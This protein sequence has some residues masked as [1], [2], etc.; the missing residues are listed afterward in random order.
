VVS[1][2]KK[3]TVVNIVKTE[4]SIFE[5]FLNYILYFGLGFLVLFYIL[6]RKFG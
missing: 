5:R 1:I 6:A 4:E 3:N 2:V